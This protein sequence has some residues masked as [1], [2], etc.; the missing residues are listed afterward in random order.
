MVPH[1]KRCG[2]PT[3]NAP[4]FRI[5]CSERIHYVIE[6]SVIFLIRLVET[7][8]I[9]DF[10]PYIL[11]IDSVEGYLFLGALAIL[12]SSFLL[13]PVL[14]LCSLEQRVRFLFENFSA[15]CF[16]CRELDVR[17]TEREEHAFLVLRP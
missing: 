1:R 17:F 12:Q 5:L 15:T 2:F 8:F 7:N 16:F 6:N 3:S 11:S 14:H 13:S 9:L 4:P 10:Q